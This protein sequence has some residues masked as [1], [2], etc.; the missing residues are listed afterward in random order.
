[1]IKAYS[2]EIEL[3]KHKMWML[4]ILALPLVYMQLGQQL[5]FPYVYHQGISLSM[6][7]NFLDYS[8]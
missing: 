8:D 6:R 1:M 2:H 7:N 4:T 3:H 5:L